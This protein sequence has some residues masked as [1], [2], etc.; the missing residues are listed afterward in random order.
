MSLPEPAHNKGGAHNTLRTG[1]GTA[2]E[3]PLRIVNF[4]RPLAMRMQSRRSTRG[5]GA[6]AWKPEIEPRDTDISGGP[7]TIHSPAC[8]SI[9][10]IHTFRRARYHRAVSGSRFR[11]GQRRSGASARMFPHH[12]PGIIQPR[13]KLRSRPFCS[14]VSSASTWSCAVTIDSMM[15]RFISAIFTVCLPIAAGS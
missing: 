10:A 2:S 8:D 9:F 3:T 5:S 7:S 11:N 6:R 1:A 15:G 4:R 12:S 13:P 14:V